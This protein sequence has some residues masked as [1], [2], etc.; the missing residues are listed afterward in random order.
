MTYSQKTPEEMADALFERY[1]E[2][3]ARI[4]SMQENY[5]SAAFDVFGSLEGGGLSAK[6][7]LEGLREDAAD[8]YPELPQISYTVEEIPEVLRQENTLA[9]YVLA[10]LDAETD[11]EI[12]YK[13]NENDTAGFFMTLAHEGYPGH[14]Y[15]WNYFIENG[16]PRLLM[17]LDT[18]GLMEGWAVYVEIDS[19]N[20]LDCGENDAKQIREAY[21]IDLEL[22]YLI[23]SLADIL[24][25]YYGYDRDALTQML[26]QMGLDDEAAGELYESSVDTPGLYPRYYISSLE[27][28]TLREE[29]E[30]RLGA[31]FDAMTFNKAV[32]DAGICYFSQLADELEEQ[33]FRY[34][35]AA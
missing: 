8:E 24:V 32:L 34:V 21:S 18:T 35:A 11:N 16:E 15:Q 29:A 5:G 17:S 3:V 6:E 2:L 23:C 20:Y 13:P 7:I 25:T 10:P 1:D 31:A 12:F 4:T 28:L 26:A 19:L 14:M 30:E 27:L 22:N 9:Y 33:D